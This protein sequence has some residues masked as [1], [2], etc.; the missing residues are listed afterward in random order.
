VSKTKSARIQD[1]FAEL[2][3][4]RRRKVTYPLI[5]VVV[6]AV[7]AVICGADDFVAIA[8]FGE[9]KRHWFREFLDLRNGIPSHDRFNA[10]LAAIKP[11]EF[12]K[13][14]LS[15]ITALHEI[16]DG[17]VIAIDGKTLRRSFDAASS[18]SA[19]HMVSAWAT[20]NHIS[21]GQVVVDQKSNEITAIPKLLEMLELSGALVT[22]DAMGCQVEIARKIVAGGADYVLTAKD[23]QPTLRGGLEEF[24]EDHLEDDFARTQV[25]RY[26]TKEEGHGREEIRDYYLCPVPDDLPDRS[27][28]EKLSAIGIVISDTWRDGE[29]HIEIRYYILSRYLS[30]KRFAE[31]VRNHWGI[32]NNLH[33]QLDVTFREDECR[34]RKGHADANFSIVRRAA[35]SLLKNE[36]TLKVGIKNKRLVAAWDESYL[37]KV[38]L[39]T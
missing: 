36:S 17:Q 33:W 32:E 22:I 31:A 7:C 14:L 13:C 39:G 34:I 5:N 37:E 29:N 15:W 1:H 8:E 18:K 3:D 2:T 10:I 35:L 16:T 4:P 24:F 11:A 9:K 12:E 19:I 25:R 26:H 23:N 27:R 6:I 20:A 21:L 30:G 28:W 38:L